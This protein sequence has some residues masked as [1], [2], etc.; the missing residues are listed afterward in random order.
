MLGS[1][2]L[3]RTTVSKS[4]ETT[5]SRFS[6]VAVDVYDETGTSGHFRDVLRACHPFLGSEPSPSQSFSLIDA[7]PPSSHL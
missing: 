6:L 7:T 5:F 2:P 3:V 1:T 4:T